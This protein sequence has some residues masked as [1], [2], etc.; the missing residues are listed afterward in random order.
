MP[1]FGAGYDNTAWA[2]VRVCHATCHLRPAPQPHL[3]VLAAC[4][5]TGVI[6]DLIKEDPNYKPPSDYRPRKFQVKV[7]SEHMVQYL[8]GLVAGFA[9]TF[10][11]VY[12]YPSGGQPQRV[13]LYAADL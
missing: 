4:H 11:G 13:V 7:G 3:H 6:E 5:V 1:C 2:C 12:P 9:V 10:P 8:M